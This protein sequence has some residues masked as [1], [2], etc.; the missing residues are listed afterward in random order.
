MDSRR[1][2]AEL[3]AAGDFVKSAAS[4][5]DPVAADAVRASLNS[6]SAQSPRR[7]P[8]TSDVADGR[9][10]PGSSRRAPSMENW[11][12]DYDYDYDYWDGPPR[13]DD[14]LTAAEAALELGVGKATIRQWAHRG[15]LTSS[16]VRGRARLYERGD[17]R[18]AKA[19][20]QSKT[21]RP[22]PASVVR[23]ELTR[24]P[25]STHEAAEIAG[26]APSTIRMWVHRGLLGPLPAVGPGHTFDPIEVLRIARR[27]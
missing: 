18:R 16:G 10:A 2:L 3:R 11:W 17:L 9:P 20:A 21:R 23:R 26:V 22:A 13:P 25:V 19:Q 6:S 4:V 24:R 14:E 7:N 12:A 1:V 8:F 5:L 27:R 15:Y